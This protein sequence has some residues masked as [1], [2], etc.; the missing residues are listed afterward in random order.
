HKRQQQESAKLDSRRIRAFPL[1]GWR[2]SSFQDRNRRYHRPFLPP[3]MAI[4]EGLSLASFAPDSRGAVDARHSRAPNKSAHAN[5]RLAAERLGLEGKF[6]ENSFVYCA[7]E[8]AFDCS[9]FRD[10][11]FRPGRQ[12]Q[13]GCA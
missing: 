10:G 6:Y 12:G 9:S 7:G 1:V 2:I 8:R 5:R 3:T 4:D 11:R 13:K